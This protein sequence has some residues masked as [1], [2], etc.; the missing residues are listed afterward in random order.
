M[1]TFFRKHSVYNLFINQTVILIEYFKDSKK[2]ADEQ[3]E[4]LKRS[5]LEKKS[6]EKSVLDLQNK[7]FVCIFLLL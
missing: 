5:A 7:V 4:S 6:N 2:T 3:K 1:V